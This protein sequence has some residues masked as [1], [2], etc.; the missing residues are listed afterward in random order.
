MGQQRQALLLKAVSMP[1]I[2]FGRMGRLGPSQAPLL[3]FYMRLGLA[4]THWKLADTDARC[5]YETSM[6]FWFGCASVSAVFVHGLFR[7]KVQ[8][9]R[10]QCHISGRHERGQCGLDPRDGSFAL[11]C[12]LPPCR[13]LLNLP[14]SGQLVS[15]TLSGRAL[16]GGS[17]STPRS[18][19]FRCAS[20]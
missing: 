10:A 17:N 9:R 19:A 3:T 11:I 20:K 18:G 13:T 7:R 5:F 2:N 12:R 1:Y 8:S 15:C 6:Q 14:R 16:T 4:R